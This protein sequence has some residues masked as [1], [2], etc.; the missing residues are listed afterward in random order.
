MVPIKALE[1]VNPSPKLPSPKRILKASVVPEMT[2]VSNPNRRPPSAATKV[3]RKSSPETP[4]SYSRSSE[5]AGAG[6]DESRPVLPCKFVGVTGKD[7]A[8]QEGSRE[9]HGDLP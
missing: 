7:L 8:R 9:H 3:L 1:T 6:G 2:A 4:V 5:L